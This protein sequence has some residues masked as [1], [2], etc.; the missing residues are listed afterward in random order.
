MSADFVKCQCAKCAEYIEF[1][2][3]NTGAVIACPHCEAEMILAVSTAPKR[4]KIVTMI[5]EEAVTKKRFELI[6]EATPSVVE[7]RLQTCGSVLAGVGIVGAVVAIV[8]A[9][10]QSNQDG[11]HPG[12][13][14]V[15]GLCSLAQGYAFWC[16]FSG[17]A[18]VIKLLRARQQFDGR[19]TRNAETRLHSCSECNA[20][21]RPSQTVCSKCGSE[22]TGQGQ[23]IRYGESSV[24]QT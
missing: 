5:I 19:I 10:G 3:E 12:V 1:D 8:N 23:A 17:G 7:N 13:W 21:V 15:A 6:K 14:V 22:L 24:N 9:V 18:E 2:P 11:G 4:G 20:K 16:L